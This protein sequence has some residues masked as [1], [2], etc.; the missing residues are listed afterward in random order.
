LA[1][2]SL[3]MAS[4]GASA[5]SP[6]WKATLSRAAGA[7]AG[8][9]LAAEAD[10]E[11]CKAYAYG[12]LEASTAREQA[13]WML[14]DCATSPR[15]LTSSMP[16]P[17]SD[18]WPDS[19][20]FALGAAA[21]MAK[22]PTSSSAGLTKALFA[23]IHWQD[24]AGAAGNAAALARARQGALDM[25]PLLETAAKLELGQAALAKASAPPN[26]RPYAAKLVETRSEALRG[27]L[28]AYFFATHE[29]SSDNVALANQA[30][31]WSEQALLTLAAQ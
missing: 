18:R 16:L 19:M 9:A 5:A 27:A 14:F 3:A 20:A 24:E 22:P 21:A 13:A 15:P 28:F 6:S 10:F 12:K 29:R 11:A 23:N 7:A 30:A 17:P 1:I 25:W 26:G 4:S 8:Q 2:L 31:H